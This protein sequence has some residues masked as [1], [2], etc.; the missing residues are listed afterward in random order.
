MDDDTDKVP[1][2]LVGFRTYCEW[3]SLDSH[4]R[5]V[6]LAYHWRQLVGLTMMIGSQRWKQI[7]KNE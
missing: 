2:G 5:G 1:E 4:W 6:Y 7:T 3:V